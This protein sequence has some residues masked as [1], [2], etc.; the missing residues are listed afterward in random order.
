MFLLVDIKRNLFIIW[1]KMKHEVF[2]ISFIFANS[3]NSLQFVQCNEKPFEDI[4]II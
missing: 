1:N 4:V 3:L 2:A